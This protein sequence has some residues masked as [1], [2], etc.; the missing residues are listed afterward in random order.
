MV[1]ALKGPAR[2]GPTANAV[3]ERG[4]GRIQQLF[5]RSTSRHYRQSV[6]FDVVVGPLGVWVNLAI[7]GVDRPRSS[8]SGRAEPVG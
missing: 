6:I 3:V 5:T 8:G 4:F 7:H 2:F 1:G